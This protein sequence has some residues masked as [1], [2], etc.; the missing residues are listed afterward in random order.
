MKSTRNQIL[1]IG[2][3]LWDCY[4]ERRH[5]G[6]APVNLA[7][8]VRM[9][10]GETRI[11]TAV[12]A[13]PDGD[14][15]LAELVR[16]GM[17][18]DLV[19]RDSCHPTGTV[20]VECPPGGEPRYRIQ[21]NVA[22]D[23]LELTEPLRRTAE[24]ASAIC[25]GTLAQRNDK[26]R[27]TIEACRSQAGDAIVLYDV[28][29]RQSYYTPQIVRRSLEAADI[30]KLDEK[31]ARVVPA[32]LELQVTEPLGFARLLVDRFEVSTVCI[33]R[34]AR[35]C[36]VVTADQNLEIPGK[37]VRPLDPVGAGDAFTA[38]FLVATL[39]GKPATLCAELANSYAALKVE[40]EGAMPAIDPARIQELRD[41]FGL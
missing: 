22:Y 27:R 10:G 35:G 32:L 2:E 29:L 3:A 26:T 31:E 25:F 16:R 9:L 33:T 11:A 37:S 17:E 21:S 18:I 1:S 36:L 6:G 23:H 20:S 19:Q 13:D 41:R 34:G 8:H 38:A 24:T 5:P 14:D 40:H 30:V 7:F 15:L 12:G 39:G 28:N 4:G